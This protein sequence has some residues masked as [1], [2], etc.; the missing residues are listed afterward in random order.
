M[1]CIPIFGT[2]SIFIEKLR[3][4]DAIYDKDQGIKIPAASC[5]VLKGK[6]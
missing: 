1:H 5:G 6:T 2:K 4:Q 3:I